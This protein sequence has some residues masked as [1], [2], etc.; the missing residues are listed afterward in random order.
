[1]LRSGLSWITVWIMLASFADVSV[2]Q[3]KPEGFEQILTRGDI[4]AIDN[5]QY[6]IADKARIDDDSFVLGVV[7]EGTP[8]AFSLNLLNQ[9]EIVNDTIGKTNFA[10]VW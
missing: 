7:I 5:P 6:V 2:G 3:E 1:M 10:A 4:P 8:M 9:H